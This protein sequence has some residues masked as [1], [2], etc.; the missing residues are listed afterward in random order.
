M[1]GIRDF[2]FPTMSRLALGPTLPPIIWVLG[3]LTL[4]IDLLVHEADHSCLSN[5]EVKDG[6]AILLLIP[7]VFVAWCLINYLQGQIYL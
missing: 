1:V 4:G 2:F 3:D 7:Y 5:A 6:G